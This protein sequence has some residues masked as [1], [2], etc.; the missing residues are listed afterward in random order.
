M[1]SAERALDVLETLGK[2]AGPL[3]AATIARLCGIP[4]SSTYQLLNVLHRRGFVAVDD[5][6]RWSL[7]VGVSQLGANGPSLAD[8]FAVLEAFDHEPGGL[9]VAELTR[10]T[11]I[12]ATHVSRALDA[13][14][15]EGLVSARGEGI[16]DIALRT[17]LLATDAGPAGRLRAAG[18]PVLEDLRDRTGETA[19]L[20]VRE[21]PEA[22]Y[23]EQVESR[24]ALRHTGWVGRRIPLGDSA[25]GRALSAGRGIEVVRDR[26]EPGV[27]AIASAIPGQTRIPAAL[28]ITGPTSR[29]RGEAL[30]QARKAVAAAVQELAAALRD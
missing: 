20:V 21:G 19:N 2:R 29:L 8:A 23:L 1:R 17:M 24:H 14:A 12:H 27:T 9:Y 6:H 25:S 4:R 15:T 30:K 18:R 5:A 10:R 13:L 16:Y 22:V 7:G 11:G 3:D 28:S 26:V